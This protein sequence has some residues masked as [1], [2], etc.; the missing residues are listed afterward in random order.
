MRP[1]QQVITVPTHSSLYDPI[2]LRA[3]LMPHH[4]RAL[5]DIFTAPVGTVGLMHNSSGAAIAAW[6]LTE[7]NQDDHYGEALTTAPPQPAGWISR[8]AAD[9]AAWLDRRHEEGE[10]V[11]AWEITPHG[12][13]PLTPDRE[14]QTQTRQTVRD[15]LA[16]AGRGR[17]FILATATTKALFS[18]SD[19][20]WHSSHHG[21]P[22]VFTGPYPQTTPAELDALKQE[23]H[24]YDTPFVETPIPHA[25]HSW[26]SH[27]EHTLTQVAAIT[28]VAPLPQLTTTGK[29]KQ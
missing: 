9:P 5:L 12:L 21:C 24:A 15:V 25:A 22:I 2:G 3:H 8:S 6:H 23:P 13:Y 17:F 1:V 14:G 7:M 18:S 11:A 29:G 27:G 4:E 16:G 20:G 10:T 19:G 26:S 28:T